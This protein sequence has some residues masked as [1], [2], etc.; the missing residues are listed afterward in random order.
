MA[1]SGVSEEL[2]QIQE[3]HQERQPQTRGEAGPQ[4]CEQ[5]SMHDRAKAIAKG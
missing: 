5:R 2:E 3:E 1:G 4:K